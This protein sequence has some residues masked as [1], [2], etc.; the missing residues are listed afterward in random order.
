MLR[1]AC[2]SSRRSFVTNVTETVRSHARSAAIIDHS[3]TYSYQDVLNRARAVALELPANVKQGD[4]LC[5]MVEPG[6]EFVST[7]WATWLRGLVAVPLCVKHPIDELSYIVDN[8]QP[9]CL[10]SSARHHDALEAASS[11]TGATHLSAMNESNESYTGFV[12]EPHQPALMIY[13]SGTTG[14][15]K[16]AIHTSSSLTAQVEA[17]H[18]AWDYR[19]SDVILHCLPLHHVH[20]L[21]NKL[22]AFNATG[23]TVKMESTFNAA[24]VLDELLGINVNGP[25]TNVFMAVPTIYVKLLEEAKRRNLTKGDFET[26]RLMVSG[27]A[28]MPRPVA[29]AWEAF[30]DT[31][32]LERYG[33]TEIGMALSQGLDTDTRIDGSVGQPMRGVEARIR[34]ADNE[35]IAFNDKASC[36]G[37]LEIKSNSLFKEYWRLPEK[38]EDEFTADGWFKTGDTS[39]FHNGHSF[40][41]GRTSVDIIKCGGYKLSALEIERVLLEHASIKEAAIV[42]IEDETW[43]ERVCLIGAFHY[44]LTVDELRHWA[45]DKLASYKIPTKIIAVDNELPKNQMGKVNK[46]ELK[47]VL[48]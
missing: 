32:L 47:R 10:Y 11:G 36:E 20:G 4:R 44:P 9:S 33:M 7:L 22:I 43:G 1:S 40:I 5:F 45:S 12:W 42:G 37:E 35:L 14:R 23:A 48:L 38:T 30:S 3:G 19:S 46:K 2:W 8:S 17:L 13:T 29:K 16:G 6:I 31:R 18:A 39:R 41:L 26:L 27:S 25:K 24:C 28:A 21:V 15:P 34:T